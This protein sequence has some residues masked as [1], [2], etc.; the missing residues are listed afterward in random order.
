MILLF[1]FT[2]VTLNFKSLF[3][4]GVFVIVGRI[5]NLRVSNIKNYGIQIVFKQLYLIEL[6]Y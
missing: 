5:I 4:A 2:L 3:F 1:F 6:N